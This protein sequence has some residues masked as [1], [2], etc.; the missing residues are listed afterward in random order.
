MVDEMLCTDD[1]DVGR[2]WVKLKGKNERWLVTTRSGLIG[3]QLSGGRDGMSMC[4][5]A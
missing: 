5:I 3:M 1:D 4:I 2:I